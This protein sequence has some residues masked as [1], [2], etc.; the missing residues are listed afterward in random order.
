MPAVAQSTQHEPH[1]STTFPSLVAGLPQFDKDAFA[2]ELP[3]RHGCAY[4]WMG[5]PLGEQRWAPSMK[6]SRGGWVG[7]DQTRAQVC[8]AA[9]AMRVQLQPCR[10]HR[11]KCAVGG[12]RK[13]DKALTC[14][15]GWEN[16]SFR[17]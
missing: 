13:R 8:A 6:R 1:P 4:T 14:N 11:T 12:L 10:R 9:A 3:K 2:A 17:G 5:K 15:D 7:L 16:A